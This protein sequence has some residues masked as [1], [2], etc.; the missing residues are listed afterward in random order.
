MGLEE[1]FPATI[2]RL[3]ATREKTG[4]PDCVK[5]ITIILKT[6]AWHK[7]QVNK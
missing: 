1:A 6:I 2:P 7:N 4:K 5:I 3:R